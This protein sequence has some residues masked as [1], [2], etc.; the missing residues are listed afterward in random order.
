[1]KLFKEK[2]EES[3]EER[4]ANAFYS[5]KKMLEDLMETKDPWE[6]WHKVYNVLNTTDL[7]LILIMLAFFDEEMPERT[8]SND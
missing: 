6:R 4:E 5:R 3:Q 8:E 7:I 2:V 1:M